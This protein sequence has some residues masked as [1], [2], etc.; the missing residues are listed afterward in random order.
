[1][2]SF[3]LERTLMFNNLIINFSMV[4]SQVKNTVLFTFIQFL[5]VLT[6]IEFQVAN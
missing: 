3:I 2:I 6:Y 4:E 1:M 5:E